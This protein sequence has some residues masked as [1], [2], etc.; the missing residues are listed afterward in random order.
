M[1]DKKK[2]LNTTNQT[3]NRP[4]SHF[5]VEVTDKELAQPDVQAKIEAYNAVHDNLGDA[6][7]DSLTGKV[8]LQIAKSQRLNK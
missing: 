5:F 6:T 1:K 7:Q 8:L 3:T 2:N 4:S